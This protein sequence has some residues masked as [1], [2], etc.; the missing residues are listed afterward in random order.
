MALGLSQILCGLAVAVSNVD[1]I[2][3]TIRLSAD[4]ADARA[5]LTN[6]KW[7]A[8]KSKEFIILIDDPYHKINP[9]NSYYLSETQAK[10]ILELRLQ[11]LTALG[12]K[13]VTEELVQLS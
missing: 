10:A 12:V 1:E 6:K 5:K 11:R 2:V 9:D 3:D 13:E 8:D 4:P 7:P